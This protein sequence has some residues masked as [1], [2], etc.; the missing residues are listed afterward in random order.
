VLDVPGGH[1][2][3]VSPVPYLGGVAIVAA[4][5]V[6]VVGAAMLHQPSGGFV[7]LAVIIGLALAIS[8]V[9]LVDDLRGLGPLIRFGA[10]TAAAVGIWAVGIGTN[11]FPGLAYGQWIDLAITIVWLVGITNAFNLLDN[12]DGLSAGVA[13][14]AAGFLFLIAALNGQFLV[15]ALAIA[16]AGCAIGF[17]RHNFHPARI[18]MGDAGSL[19]IG[20]LLAV[21]GIKLSVPTAPLIAAFVPILVLGVAIFD[22]TLVTTTRLTHRRSPFSGG[23][24]H[25]SHRLVHVG[26]PVPIAVAL[27]YGAAVAAGWLGVVMARLQDLATAYLLLGFTVAVAVF[28]GVMLAMVP[29]YESS[30]RRRMMIREV[31][32]HEEPVRP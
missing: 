7:E 30:Q 14:I 21:L 13:A 22:T 10:V 28:L 16:L 6:A 26:I 17:L 8:L 32:E 4:F 18:Y 11:L 23:R 19:F 12:M 20:F 15:A 3:H 24:D 1:K 27:I 5:S 2:S 9:G 31:A 25:V 29:V